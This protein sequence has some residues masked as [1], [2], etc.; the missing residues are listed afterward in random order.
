VSSSVG[1]ERRSDAVADA[2]DAFAPFYDV[3]TEHQDYDWWWSVLLPLVEAA[4]LSGSRVL[5]VACGT[6]KSLG[7]LLERG[8]SALG[9]D[10][11]TGML[12]E[13]RRKLGPDVTLAEHDM[14]SLPE[15]GEF[16]LVSCLNDAINNLHDEQ[17]LEE[18]FKGFRRN[19]SS[20]GVVLF[21]VNTIGTFRSYAALVR[22]E[23]DR[24]LVVEGHGDGALPPGGLLPLDFV[25][26]ERRE[27]FWSCDRTSHL[28]RHHP[29]AEIRRALR[30]AGLELVEVRG[31]S[32]FVVGA[33]DELRDEKAVYVARVAPNERERR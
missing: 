21:D 17:Q 3:L 12:A 2:Y 29:D 23:P 16:D 1:A 24:V 27:H 30:S 13:A 8:W 22:P 5:D 15:L 26:F 14:R 9:V 25:V 20:R 11:S 32:G 33:L 4:G 7:P 28:Q 10:A 18:T 6:G 19:L 31:Q